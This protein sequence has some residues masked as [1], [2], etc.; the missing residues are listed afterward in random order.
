M[1]AD[2]INYILSNSVK[3]ILL[4]MHDDGD[5]AL[6]VSATVILPAV[7]VLLLL[8][9]MLVNWLVDDGDRPD[10]AQRKND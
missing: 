7:A 2:A 10:R 8:A 9:F 5:F 3:D 4:R 1:Y 6:A